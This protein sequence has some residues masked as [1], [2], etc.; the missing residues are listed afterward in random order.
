M[1]LALLC[2]IWLITFVSTYFFVAK[3]WWLPKGVAAAAPGIDNQFAITYIA[4][5]V[6]FVLAQCALGFLVWKYRDRS[7]NRKVSYSHGNTKLEVLWTTLTAILFIALN[8]LGSPIW[9]AERFDPPKPGAIPVEVTG[10]QFA[11][12][13][14]YPGVDAKFGATKPD[15]MDPSAGNESA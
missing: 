9:A 5:G 13:F 14:R 1:G 7:D 8:L 15:L 2:I 4:M 11:W 6:V 10:M 3:T 12:Y